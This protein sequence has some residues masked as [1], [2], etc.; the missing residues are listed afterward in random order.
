M[1]HAHSA[2]PPATGRCT[3]TTSSSGSPRT[4]A[5]SMPA[6][7][8]ARGR[9]RLPPTRS[10]ARAS[11]SRPARTPLSRWSSPAAAAVVVDRIASQRRRRLGAGDARPLG[12][13]RIPRRRVRAAPAA[14]AAAAPRA[15]TG[16]RQHLLLL[17][18]SM[19]HAIYDG[20]SFAML[21]DEI[22]VR[23]QQAGAAASSST[24][25]AGL[26]RRPARASGRAR[27][28]P[29]QG[30]LAGGV[31]GLPTHLRSPGRGDE[32]GVG[33]ARGGTRGG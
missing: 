14:A 21:L 7:C 1:L 23:Y 29:S 10:C 2:A 22:A 24:A 3:S 31:Q 15:C 27:H 32:G 19:H 18:I 30:L 6:G 25:V 13:H 11:A 20:Q 9:L 28:R 5:P 17:R 12:A 33:G 4:P 8:A 16:A 26:A